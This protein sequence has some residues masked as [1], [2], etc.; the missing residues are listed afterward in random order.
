MKIYS[1][2]FWCVDR[3]TPRAPDGAKN[4]W[5]LLSATSRTSGGVVIRG[6]EAGVHE[7]GG[8]GGVLHRLH[9][10]ATHEGRAA[11]TEPVAL[12][13]GHPPVAGCKKGFMVTRLFISNP[14]QPSPPLRSCLYHCSR[15]S[16]LARRRRS[17]NQGTES[18][19]HT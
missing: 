9:D 6:D 13:A 1:L 10:V 16:C 7:L 12:D 18:S 15:S 5:S 11:L 4:V 2:S 17:L 19:E 14:P 8:G 3:Q